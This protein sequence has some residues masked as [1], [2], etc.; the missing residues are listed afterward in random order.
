MQKSSV[1]FRIRRHQKA[2]WTITPGII[3]QVGYNAT[4]PLANSKTGGEVYAILYIAVSYIRRT[5]TCSNRGK[6]LNAER[7]KTAGRNSCQP[8]SISHSGS[9]EYPG[10]LSAGM[11]MYDRPPPRRLRSNRD[12][13]N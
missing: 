6:R 5:L 2:G 7:L 1:G 3:Q 9:R 8:A 12:L 4:C 10:H 11:P 13:G